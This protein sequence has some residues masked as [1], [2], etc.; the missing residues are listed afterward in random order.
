M[1]IEDENDNEKSSSDEDEIETDTKKKSNPKNVSVASADA[2]DEWK[3]THL[4]KQTVDLSSNASFPFYYI[5][6]DDEDSI[7]NEAKLYEQKK[8]KNK[9]KK[10]DNIDEDDEDETTK[11]GK[12]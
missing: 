9:M 6:I 12:E 11:G 3:K 4:T 5:V 8:L 1:K 10:L 2:F 7:V